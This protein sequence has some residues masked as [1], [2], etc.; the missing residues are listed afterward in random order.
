M[1]FSLRDAEL[2]LGIGE[3]VQL[4]IEVREA[5]V[6]TDVVAE[7]FRVEEGI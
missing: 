4:H 6:R 3:T 7:L 1:R 2:H 5:C